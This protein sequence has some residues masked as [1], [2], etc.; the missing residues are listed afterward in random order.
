MPMPA[1][2]GQVGPWRA[3]SAWQQLHER[4]GGLRTH[5]ALTA[6]KFTKLPPHGRH[7][8]LSPDVARYYMQLLVFLNF[9]NSERDRVKKSS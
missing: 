7:T 9:K 8:D 5:L 2:G 4:R 1:R 6:P 3:T